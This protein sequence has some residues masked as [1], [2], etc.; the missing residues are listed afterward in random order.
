MI[1]NHDP[2]MT[3]TFC[4]F[5]ERVCLCACLR[6]EVTR[7]S[8]HRNE[9]LQKC[10]QGP[11]SVFGNDPVSLQ[12]LNLWSDSDKEVRTHKPRIY[13]SLK[14]FPWAMSPSSSTNVSSLVRHHKTRL[15]GRSYPMLIVGVPIFLQPCKT[16]VLGGVFF[17]WLAV[18]LSSI[19]L[20]SCF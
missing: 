14:Y 4:M 6:Q 2:T 12:T 9:H 8:R 3:R 11:K 20:T 15:Q 18:C 19:L 17:F 7:R 16:F 1:H 5:S 10:L 13:P